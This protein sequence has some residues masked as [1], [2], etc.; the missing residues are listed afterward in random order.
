VRTAAATIERRCTSVYGQLVESTS[1]SDRRWAI[2]ALR[3]CALREL[4]FGARPSDFP[5]L[6]P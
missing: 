2:T 1:G 4:A 6:N 3:G 5:G